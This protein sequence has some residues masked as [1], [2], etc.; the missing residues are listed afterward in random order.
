MS[1]QKFV[2]TKQNS[3]RIS[4]GEKEMRKENSE[5][6]SKSQTVSEK[7]RLFRSWVI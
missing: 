3:E 6:F 7:E 5:S 4:D 1:F 2:P